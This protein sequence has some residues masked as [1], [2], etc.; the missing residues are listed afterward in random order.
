MS[1]LHAD[2]AVF[3]K[4][5]KWSEYNFDCVLEN[6]SSYIDLFWNWHLQIIDKFVLNVWVD[7]SKGQC[8][9]LIFTFCLGDSLFWFNRLFLFL[10]FLFCFLFNFWFLLIRRVIFFL[11]ISIFIE[12]VLIKKN[13]QLFSNFNE[14]HLILT[15]VKE[16][17]IRPN[18]IVYSLELFNS[19]QFNNHCFQFSIVNDFKLSL[20]L[21]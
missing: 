17:K 8:I 20:K 19:R 21:L 9:S 7:V 1:V 18:K 11:L 16:G 2:F 5:I 3:L 6:F 4:V 13:V 14:S 15:F 10:C 12:S